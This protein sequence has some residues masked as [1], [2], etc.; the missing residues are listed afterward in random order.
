M[1]EEKKEVKTHEV[2]EVKESVLMSAADAMLE[3][4]SILEPAAPDLAAE[5][6]DEE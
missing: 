4:Q 5:D 1:K 2:V 6:W 3:S